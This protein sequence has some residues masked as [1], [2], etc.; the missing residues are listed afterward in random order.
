MFFFGLT[1]I[2]LNESASEGL[3]TQA[4]KQEINK[5]SALVKILKRINESASE[6]IHVQGHKINLSL[7]DCQLERKIQKT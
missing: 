6:M 3:N 5:S 2:F 7:D 1:L 4:Q